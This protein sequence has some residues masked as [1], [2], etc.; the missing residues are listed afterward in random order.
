MLKNLE[1]GHEFLLIHQENSGAKYNHRALRRLELHSLQ[2]KGQEYQ[3]LAEK[4]ESSINRP[5]EK[6]CDDTIFGKG[7]TSS[8]N[9]IHDS[10]NTSPRNLRT[11]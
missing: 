3:E 6:T 1:G 2:G 5:K 11:S 8:I 7:G 9:W 10:P 4:P